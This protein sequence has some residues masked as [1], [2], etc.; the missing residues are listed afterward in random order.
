MTLKEL[1]EGESL[2]AVSGK[3]M[4]GS[5]AFCRKPW[6]ASRK[7]EEYDHGDLSGDIEERKGVLINRDAHQDPE[8]KQTDEHITRPA[9]SLPR[10]EKQPGGQHEHDYKRSRRTDQR[11]GRM[12]EHVDIVLGPLLIGLIGQ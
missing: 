3:V 8:A 12:E 10:L 2:L 7:E 4:V 11:G 9:S 1:R 6:P 5:R